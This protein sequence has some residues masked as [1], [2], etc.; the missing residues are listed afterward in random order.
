MQPVPRH[1][2][3]RLLYTNPVCVLLSA[4]QPPAAAESVTDSSSAYNCM[5][6]SW[7]TPV[8][9]SG[10]FCMSLKSSRHTTGNLLRDGRFTLSPACEGMEPLLLRL[11]SSSGRAGVRK[12]EAC[13]VQLAPLGVV[14]A[15]ADAA[16][17]HAPGV[18]WRGHPLP[19]IAH[20]PA[21]LLCSV[22]RVLLG[23]ESSLRTVESPVD[24]LSERPAKRAARG[25]A[26]DD[27]RER[28]GHTLESPG[29]TLFLCAVDAAWVAPAYWHRGKIFGGEQGTPGILAFAG[30]KQF[31]TMTLLREKEGEQN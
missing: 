14:A 10:M 11:G 3:S 8:D 9:N 12:V 21:H 2:H 31:V 26:A 4:N 22:V 20:A 19:A 13:G 28:P 15:A 7:L 29:H 18:A 23:E 25:G 24:D 5:T 1:L 6:V 27:V 30:S 16:A 17:C